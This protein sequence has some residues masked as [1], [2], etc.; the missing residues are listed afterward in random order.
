MRNAA[1]FAPVLFA[2]TLLAPGLAYAQDAY[3]RFPDVHGDTVVFTAEGDLFVAPVV[4]GLARR[5]TIHDGTERLAQ[6]SADGKRIAFTADYDGNAEV[7]VM[8]ATGGEPRRLTIHPGADEVM[9]WLPD[10][11]VLF[12]SN[13]NEPH[14]RPE[15]WA[16]AET[17]GEPQPLPL[18]WASRLDA[19]PKSGQWAFVRTQWETRTW[20]R[21]RGGTAQDIWVGDP[22]KSDFRQVTS[23]RGTDA[24]PMWWDGRIT[25]LSDQGG[26]MNLWSMAP[27]GSDRRRLT[28]HGQWDARW[29][30]RADD[31]RVAY[32]LAGDIHLWEPSAGASRRLNIQLPSDAEL[33]RART[34]EGAPVTWAALSPDGDRV[35]VLSRG[36]IHSVPVEDGPTLAISRS[37]GA[38]ES[39]ASY[40]PDGQRIVYVSDEGG[41]EQ[42]HTA[43]AW[44]RGDVRVVHP[45]PGRGWHFPP[46]WSNKGDH[47]AWSDDAQRLWI[48]S[49]KG[50]TPRL[51]DTSAQAEIREYNFSP[52][53]RYLAYVLTDRQ[54]FR[55]IWVHDTKDGQSRRVTAAS[56]DDHAPAWDPKG[57]YLYFVGERNVDPMLGARDFQYITPKTSLLYAVILRTDGEDPTAELAGLPPRPGAEA[58]AEKAKGGKSTKDKKK[59]DGK[60]E[61]E[62]EKDVEVRIDWEGLSART[63]PLPV[64]AGIYDTI[65]ATADHLFFLSFPLMGMRE[66]EGGDGTPTSTLQRWSL[67]DKKQETFASGVGGYEIAG[68]GGKILLLRGQNR[69]A[70]VGT[71]SI[72]TALDDDAVD[73]SGVVSVVDPR[74]E[75]AQIFAETFR[76]MRD[77]HWDPSMRG[78]DWPAIRRQYEALLPKVRS[79]DDLRDL[80]GE[81]IGELATSHTYIGGGDMVRLPKGSS[82][83]LLGA[84]LSYERGAY[85]VQRIYRGDAADPERSPLL[86]PSAAVKEGDFILEVGGQSARADVPYTALLLGRADKSVTLLVN[87]K[88]ERDGARLVVVTP[89]GN[90]QGLRYVDWVR[91][92]RE[93]V[94]AQS[95]GALGYVHIPD[96]GTQGLFRFDTWFHPQLGKKGLVVDARWNGGGFVSQLILER[97]RRPLTAFDRS[98]GGGIWTYPARV[99]NGPFVVLTNEHAGSDGDIFPAAIQAE[100]LA[101]VI[102]AR[103]WGG[104]I[105]IRSDKGMIDGGS[106][107][108][109]EYAFFWP[110]A[111]GGWVIENEGVTP[112][113]EV[114]NLPQELAAGKDAQLER[115]LAELKLLLAKEPP[116]EPQFPVAPD[117]GRK[118]FEGEMGE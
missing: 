97:L 46:V 67:K 79:R 62:A 31:G 114:Q 47:I 56:T 85:K 72:P 19:D 84:D 38:R 9:G 100:R 101:P 45:T 115:G 90:E 14:R 37:P 60:G 57:R 73:L 8:P 96:M 109:P 78:I 55:S 24:F 110:G 23:F 44:G 108:Q 106:L 34:Q 83:G 76:H 21:Y 65:S 95:G 7:Y 22:N 98:R 25:F 1:P 104:V 28:D 66:S 36:D 92:N 113:I 32:M 43:D 102:G 63:V 15:L 35:L 51:V 88:P 52:D 80:M 54:D 69:L 29:P 82:I 26:T 20:K 5:L 86:A 89:V 71:D 81:L 105:G 103:S 11:R 94:D 39:W 111:R 10:G 3:L 33:L 12:R 18:G 27:D 49:A 50:G 107:T 93:W 59:G 4:G 77:F 118:A 91:R 58:E 75:W 53:G 74:A 99:V 116:V 13:R 64:T 41:E 6:F 61:E 68:K 30:N 17:G 87:N 48:G 2:A 42:V 16:I 117:K 70:V 40:S 112:D